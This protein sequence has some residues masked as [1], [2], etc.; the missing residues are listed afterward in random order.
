MEAD[1]DTDDA[2]AVADNPNIS[3]APGV[4]ALLH[5]LADRAVGVDAALREL[6]K[7]GAGFHIDAGDL[8]AWG[9]KHGFLVEV[10][11]TEPCGDDCACAEWDDFPQ[12]C[13][14]FAPALGTD[15][16]PRGV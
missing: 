5:R 10:E 9:L 4:R 13:I 11:A 6:F 1:L 2:H 3:M 12:P 16:P 8:Q 15:G 14:R 7:M